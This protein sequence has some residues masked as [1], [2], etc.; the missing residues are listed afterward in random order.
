[1]FVSAIAPAT[2]SSQRRECDGKRAEGIAFNLF[3]R[4][5]AFVN[6]VHASPH[7][8]TLFQDIQEI[9]DSCSFKIVKSVATRWFSQAKMARRYLAVLDGVK[10]F[11]RDGYAKDYSTDIDDF[12]VTDEEIKQLQDILTVLKKLEGI[13]TLAETITKPTLVWVC[14]WIYE[15]QTFLS[16]SDGS[17]SIVVKRWKHVLLREI[18]SRLG[19]VFDAGS[20]NGPD[21]EVVPPLLALRAACFNHVCGHLPWLCSVADRGRVWKALERDAEQ[22][23]TTA[24]SSDPFADNGLEAMR[25]AIA[26]MQSMHE[27]EQARNRNIEMFGQH[28]DSVAAF[29]QAYAKQGN[30][31]APLANLVQLF[32]AGQASSVASEQLWSSASFVRERYM[33]LQAD[34]LETHILLRWWIT[35]KSFNADALVE[36]LLKRLEGAL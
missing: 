26:K 3:G 25:S 30:V 16:T 22:L 36:E 7:R 19:D 12:V 11:I 23:C 35:R 33:Q 9:Y 34:T 24:Q 20:D 15:I 32:L 14:Q 18:S 4:I 6:F 1:L 29:W 27:N 13:C 31:G 8:G 17:D 21:G 28:M 2:Q 5:N 10:R